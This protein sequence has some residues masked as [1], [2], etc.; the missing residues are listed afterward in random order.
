MQPAHEERA[1]ALLL[2]S[3]TSF[4]PLSR[5]SSGTS[6]RLPILLGTW[7]LTF[8]VLGARGVLG[9]VSLTVVPRALPETTRRMERL[10]FRTIAE[11]LGALLR[12][13]HFVTYSL[14]G[15][16]LVVLPRPG[17]SR[18]RSAAER[19][20]VLWC[21]RMVKRAR[22]ERREAARDA[23]KM[24]RARMKLAALEPGGAP[25]RPIEVTS[26]SVIEPQATSMSCPAC[27]SQGQRIDEHIAETIDGSRLRV[28]HA[29]CPRC[30]S[31]REVYFRIG[32]VLPS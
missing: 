22:T 18:P 13:R 15:G 6:T 29:R 12:D 28:V 24:A 8:G 23:A 1:L 3:L 27:G 11:Q 21:Q 19:R 20:P 14:A 16:C 9:I 32:T 26:A 4:E 31:R 25:D 7:R 2:G 30:G 10:D 5:T 17:W